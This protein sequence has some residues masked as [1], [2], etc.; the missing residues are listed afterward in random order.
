MTN[1]ER[2]ER[3]KLPKKIKANDAYYNLMVLKMGQ[4]W[5][6]KNIIRICPV[7]YKKNV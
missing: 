1:K 5:A 3:N 2:H 7:N 6:D 4:E